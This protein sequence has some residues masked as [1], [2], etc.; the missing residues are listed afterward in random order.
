MKTKAQLHLKMHNMNTKPFSPL[1]KVLVEG[2]MTKYSDIDHL[3][4]SLMKCWP[5][6]QSSLHLLLEFPSL[7]RQQSSS[8]SRD[9]CSIEASSDCQQLPASSYGPTNPT[10]E[11]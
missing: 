6:L 10:E 4:K 2:L 11:I 7:R 8:C 9:T 1:K 5:G 3:P